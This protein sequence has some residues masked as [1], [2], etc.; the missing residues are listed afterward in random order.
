MRVR[1]TGLFATAALVVHTFGERQGFNAKEVQQIFEDK[2]GSIW[3]STYGEGLFQKPP[4]RFTYYGIDEI[5]PIKDISTLLMVH[6][7][8]LWLGGNEGLARFNIRNAAYQ[9]VN[10]GVEVA[11]TALARDARGFIW[12]GTDRHGIYVYNPVKDTMGLVNKRL[13]EP[14]ETVNQI[15]VHQGR[16]YCCTASGLIIFNENNKDVEWLRTNEGLYHNNVKNVLVD[17]QG[18][19]WVASYGSPPYYI[20]N[21]MTFPFK[22]INGLRSFDVNAYCEDKD[23]KIWIA[24][25]GDGVFSYDKDFVQYTTNEGLASDFCNG[26]V[27]G[28]DSTIWV[29]HRNGLSQKEKS[30]PRF[31]QFIKPGGVKYA[32]FCRN[33][34]YASRRGR[35]YFATKTA[36]VQY[37][38]Y[39]GKPREVIPET[40]ISLIRVDKENYEP[41]DRIKKEFGYYSIRIEFRAASLADP[42]AVR[43]KYRLLGTDTAWQ[44]T[45][46]RYVE[47]QKLA[48]G[49]FDFE[50]CALNDN[51]WLADPTPAKASIV[52]S[53]P[54]W[55]SAWFYIL[56]VIVGVGLTYIT[57]V[58]RTRSLKKSKDLLE[59]KVQE[60]T[61]LLQK[62]KESVEDIKHVMEKKNKDITDSINYAKKIQ[63]SILPSDELL[64]ELFPAG[65]FVLFEPKDIVS[66][67]FYWASTLTMFGY[68]KATLAVAALVDCTGHGVPGAFLSIMANDCLRQSMVD[69]L[70]NKPG[71]VLNFLN[72]KISSHLNQNSKTQINDG[73]DIAIIGVD[74]R[75]GILHYSGAN[76]PVYVLRKNGKGTELIIL[77]GI[78]QA[79]GM[80]NKDTT[81]FPNNEFKVKSGDRVCMFSDG[82]PDQ[83]GGQY[84]K[85]MG[86]K[87]FKELLLASAHLSM[88]DQKEFLRQKFNEWKNTEH[89]TDDM[90]LMSIQIG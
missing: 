32:D 46:A 40:Q 12:I 35:V 39:L 48:D 50:V 82:Y 55:R 72:K 85:K 77:K 47:F 42:A 37:D 57:M 89:Q 14:V 49:K 33:S 66:G 23:G 59:L 54:F 20:Q 41:T 80:V 17:S 84:N 79:I 7:S 21:Q 71:D 51:S 29:T 5:G 34:A 43:Y 75:T 90:C 9:T 25:E 2:E 83:F 3:L 22:N 18:R 11:V 58:A 86:H 73:M 36:L 76:N 4:Q 24:T 67:D 44:Y 8:D 1:E 62:E 16:I 19:L 10:T 13:G 74:Y 53:P 88:S 61:I 81:P 60:K 78:R 69:G 64:H 27:C 26:L 28:S 30:S 68:T 38:G 70:V 6:D 45:S 63:Y 52:I 56:L 15:Y 87:R 31:R 65:Y